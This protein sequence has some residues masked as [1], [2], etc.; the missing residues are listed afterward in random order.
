[1]R[2]ISI[3]ISL[4]LGDLN[5]AA[6]AVL[7]PGDGLSLGPMTLDQPE[8]LLPAFRRGPLYKLIQGWKSGAIPIPRFNHKTQKEVDDFLKFYGDSTDGQFGFDKVH[9]PNLDSEDLEWIPSGLITD[10]SDQDSQIQI[11]TSRYIYKQGET[12]V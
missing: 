2:L 3:I 7:R 6:L 1:M 10:Q 8:P 12:G 5:G 9:V 4:Q 11:D